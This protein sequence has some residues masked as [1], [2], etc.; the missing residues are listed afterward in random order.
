MLSEDLPPAGLCIVHERSRVNQGSSLRSNLS[1]GEARGA[2]V[3][4][5]YSTGH[6]VL[7]VCAKRSQDSSRGEGALSPVENTDS[8]AEA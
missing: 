4:G 1:S 8:E 7:Q 6:T 2:D 5:Q 3:P